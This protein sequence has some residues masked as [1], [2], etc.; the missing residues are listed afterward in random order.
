MLISRFAVSPNAYLS[1]PCPCDHILKLPPNAM[2]EYNPAQFAWIIYHI[3]CDI[4]IIQ[5][6]ASSRSPFY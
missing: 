2:Y 5:E 3:W 1:R 6:A 4:L